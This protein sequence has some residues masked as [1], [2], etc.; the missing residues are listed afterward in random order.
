[1]P[2]ALG[3]PGST[4][5]RTLYLLSLAAT[6]SSVCLWKSVWN[7]LEMYILPPS[8]WSEVLCGVVGLAGL[9]ATSSLVNS[10]GVVDQCASDPWGLPGVEV[11]RM[12]EDIPRFTPP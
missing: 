1:M 6:V 2:P 4:P 7:L 11:P 5:P 8:V 10:S 12:G 3:H 9:W